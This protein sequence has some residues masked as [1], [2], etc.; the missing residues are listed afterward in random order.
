[1]IPRRV[2]IVTGSRA[3]YGH[4]RWLMSDL[5]DDPAI[6][7]RVVASGTHLSP[8]HGRTADE[9]EADGITIHERVDMLLAGDTPQAV[10]KSVGLG[11]I[12]FAEALGRQQP[13][14]VV[15]LGD[16]FEM[17]AAAQAALILGLPIAHLHG[18]E[19]TEGA[20]DEAMRHAITKMA[21]LHFAAA[22]PY[23]RRIIQLG[24]APERVFN[25][26]A[27]GLD[28]LTRTTF[29]SRAELE[30]SLGITLRAPVL[31]VTYHPETLGGHD[32]RAAAA[33]MTEALDRFPE[34][35]VIATGVNADADNAAITAALER[36]VAAHPG[37]ARLFNSLGSRRYL[38]LLRCAQAMVGNSSSG[39]IEAPAFHLP[40]VNV[41]DRQKGRLRAASVRD[42]P[43]TA[44]GIAA[45]IGWAL[46]AEGQ[47]AA[48]DS[49]SLYGEGD[50]SRRIVEVL[51]THPLAGLTMKSFHD[52]PHPT[53]L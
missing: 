50:A 9:I 39:L 22:E 21:H 44:D 13:D 8:W 20:V 30:E 32:Q 25:V 52:L 3:E 29:L 51:K 4:L 16:R 35:T 2:C 24:E 27:P 33:A 15:I 31:V 28:H 47:A 34:A 37:R 17:L 11:V 45:A 1:M 43:A 48:R 40:T 26:G 46:S 38:S 7:L 12:G 49:R 23:R 53:G 6:D 5:R 42:C 14:I 36:F 41:G 18:G 19:T 10:A